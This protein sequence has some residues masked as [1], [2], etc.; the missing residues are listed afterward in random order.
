MGGNIT[1]TGMVLSALPVGEYDRRITILTK[2]RGK[3]AAFAR[4]AR[5]QGSQ[6]LAP[7][8]PFSFGRFEAYEGRRSYTVTRAEISNYFREATGDMEGA[9]YG[10]YFLEMA[11]YFTRENMDG[12]PMLKL[13]YQTMRALG[14]DSLDKRLVRRVFELKSFVLDGEY[15]DLAACREC[16]GTQGP[17]YFSPRA[18]GLL[19]GGCVGDAPAVP[20][21]EAALYAMRYVVSSPIE[22]LYTFKVSAPV[23]EMLGNA[24]DAWMGSYVDKNFHSLEILKENEGFARDFAKN[25]RLQ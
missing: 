3:V 6:L 7:S 15:P 20:L 13:L 16:R 12:L 19:C 8:G 17:F 9:C 2:E 22:K 23:L 25:P 11:D 21:D 10:F 1:L 18:G 14:C 4:G 24:V 5:R